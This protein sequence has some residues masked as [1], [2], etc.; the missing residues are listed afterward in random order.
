MPALPAST[1]TLVAHRSR[2]DWPLLWI[3]IGVISILLF[4]TLFVIA[5]LRCTNIR[6]KAR[7]R[8]L[9]EGGV[10]NL[11]GPALIWRHP[12]QSG[13]ATSSFNLQPQTLQRPDEQV[14]Q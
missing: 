10:V 12:I 9:R 6:S 5:F 11:D 14:A 3:I 4:Q 7:W 2:T 1:Q 13:P 8:R